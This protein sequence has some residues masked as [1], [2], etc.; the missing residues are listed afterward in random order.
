V[1]LAAKNVYLFLFFIYNAVYVLYMG[2][3]LNRTVYFVSLGAFFLFE[4]YIFIINNKSSHDIKRMFFR[5]ELFETLAV[6]A[7]FFVISVFIQLNNGSLRFYLV[8]EMLYFVVPCLTAYI[9]INFFDKKSVKSFFYIILLKLVALFFLKFGSKLSMSTILAINFDDSKSSLYESGYAH[10]FLFLMIVFIYFDEI[11]P[12]LIS[13]ALCVLSFKR[14]PFILSFI[15]VIAFLVNKSG[16]II[17]LNGIRNFIKKWL[18]GNFSK[19]A[20]AILF[21][22]TLLL[23][24]FMDWVYSA[25][26]VKWFKDVFS[27]DLNEYTSGRVN[28]VNYA[29]KNCT[30][31]GLGSTTDF[32]KNSPIADYRRVANLHCDV[33]RLKLEVTMAGYALYSFVLFRVFNKSRLTILLLV[34]LITEMALSHIVDNLNIWVI[35]YIFLAYLAKEKETPVGN[36]NKTEG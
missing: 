11:I 10:D 14:L 24:L 17:G 27:M 28:I 16:K 15:L 25:E 8:E 21:I 31:N 7:V 12:V 13:F 5:K 2:H 35:T 3:L 34:Y 1:K 20:I 18:N 22:V 30:L 29:L 33:I 32:F 26:G 36:K 4:L 6:A 19:A 23:P 9:C